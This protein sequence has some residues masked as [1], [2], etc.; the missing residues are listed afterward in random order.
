MRSLLLVGALVIGA[1]LAAANAV[2]SRAQSAGS[3]EAMRELSVLRAEYQEISLKVRQ[4]FALRS[5]YQQQLKEVDGQSAILKTAWD[6]IE[7]QRPIIRKLCTGKVAPDKLAEAK[8]KCD[9]ALAPFNRQ[10]EDHNEKK[11]RV[12]ARLL[13]LQQEDAERSA[14]TARLEARAELLKQRID[15]L[16]VAVGARGDTR[17]EQDQRS[18]FAASSQ[19][20]PRQPTDDQLDSLTRTARP[21]PQ[22]TI[23]DHFGRIQG[24][25]LIKQY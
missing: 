22:Q 4:S 7:A 10:V 19:Q 14:A 15:I 16:E 20:P 17:T 11:K 23:M 3:P 2:P 13:V 12:D 18:S 8:Q 25:G 1:A 9:A 21:T 5:Q 24:N 6:G